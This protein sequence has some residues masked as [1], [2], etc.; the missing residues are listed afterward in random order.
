ML[1]DLGEG[2]YEVRCLTEKGKA[3]FAGKLQASEREA[4]LPQGLRSGSIR[5]QVR[6]FVKRQFR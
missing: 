3:L 6:A 4:S 1:L 2:E 5:R